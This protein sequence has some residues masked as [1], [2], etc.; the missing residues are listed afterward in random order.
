MLTFLAWSN[1]VMGGRD[2][3][4]ASVVHG[5]QGVEI[6][7]ILIKKTVWKEYMSDG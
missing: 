2:L 6:S 5:D 3:Q 1:G 4:V 7:W